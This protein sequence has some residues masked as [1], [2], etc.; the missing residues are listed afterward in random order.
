MNGA[1]ASTAV[2]TM[3]SS[4]VIHRKTAS[5]VSQRLSESL[6]HNPRANC[7]ID[8]KVLPNTISP[9]RVLPRVLI[10]QPP[11]LFCLLGFLPLLRCASSLASLRQPK[12]R[13]CSAGR[14]STLQ[15]PDSQ[16]A[17]PPD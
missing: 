2:A 15:P 17:L 13:S 14:S 9:R 12:H 4:P 1:S 6:C 8:P 7:A 3:S 10:T 11:P 5:G 16:S